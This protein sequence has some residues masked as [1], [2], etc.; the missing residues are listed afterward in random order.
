[1]TAMPKIEASK[2]LPVPTD[3]GIEGMSCA[4]CVVRVEKAIAAVPGVA[5]PPPSTS[6]PSAQP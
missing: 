2:T 6:P 4:S 3:F 5:S 1:M